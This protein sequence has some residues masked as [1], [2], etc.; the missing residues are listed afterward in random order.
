MRKKEKI[1]GF[2]LSSSLCLSL[3]T[4]LSVSASHRSVRHRPV[5]TSLTQNNGNFSRLSKNV[6]RQVHF[7]FQVNNNHIRRDRHWNYLIGMDVKI[8][9]RSPKTVTFNLSRFTVGGVNLRGKNRLVTI[10][11]HKSAVFRNALTGSEQAYTIP[12]EEIASHRDLGRVQFNYRG[13]GK[14][15]TVDLAPMSSIFVPQQRGIRSIGLV[16]HHTHHK[17]TLKYVLKK[18]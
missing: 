18:F 16:F 14:Y 2:L 13:Y 3:A 7:T 11:A 1:V 5:T 8:N 9:N 6:Q 17:T 4:P 15:R 10:R 12:V